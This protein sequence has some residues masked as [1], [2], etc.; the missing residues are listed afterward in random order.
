MKKTLNV[1]ERVALVALMGLLFSTNAV[2]ALETA[3][4]PVSGYWNDAINWTNGVPTA[5]VTANVS[6]VS[7]FTATITNNVSAELGVLQIAY[8]K[9]QKGAI[10]MTGGT[11]QAGRLHM[12][13]TSSTGT[14]G[15][16]GGAVTIPEGRIGVNGSSSFLQSGGNLTGVNWDFG[17]NNNSVGVYTQSSGTATFSGAIDFSGLSGSKGFYCLSGDGI[18]NAVGGIRVPAGQGMITQNGG[19]LNVGT[20]TAGL[21]LGSAIGGCGTYVLNG[22]S[23]DAKYVNVGGLGWGC[24]TQ[25]AGTAFI[26]NLYVPCAAGTGSYIL[27]SGSL[28]SIDQEIGK[29]AGSVGTFEQYGG[30]NIVAGVNPYIRVGTVDTSRGS[31]AIYGGLTYC[32]RLLVAGDAVGMTNATGVI[33]VGGG[34]FETGSEAVIGRYGNGTLIQTGGV[35]TCAGTVSIGMRPGS[36][37]VYTQ[38]AGEAWFDLVYV[39]RDSGSYS[40]RYII[41]GGTATM[42]NLTAGYYQEN[43]GTVFGIIGTNAGVTVAN[44]LSLGAGVTYEVTLGP[45]GFS[46]PYAGTLDLLSASRLKV[47]SRGFL[48]DN[49]E[50]PILTFGSRNATLFGTVEVETGTKP[51]EL[52]SATPNYYSDR[53]T[54]T[55]HLVPPPGT[56]LSVR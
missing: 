13:T 38:T 6:N 25:Y 47:M 45:D 24:V 4:L 33:T 36:V 55:V 12:G 46:A 15:L 32:E 26:T 14:F 34:R 8:T 23:F 41:A 10:N 30:T 11:L 22:G 9:S 37:G 17:I 27:V 19:I 3:W 53:I 43:A 7:L 42:T 21:S 1:S 49:V 50:V 20:S 54:L 40:N 5:T 16:S 18:M 56:L 51:G 48:Q 39:G 29:G 44:K 31:Y 52:K 35:F 28:T 2:K